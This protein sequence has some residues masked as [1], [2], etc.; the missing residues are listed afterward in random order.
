MLAGN[1]SHLGREDCKNLSV[2]LRHIQ[3]RTEICV[4]RPCSPP[5]KLWAVDGRETDSHSPVNEDIRLLPWKGNQLQ[6]TGLPD[7]AWGFIFNGVAGTYMPWAWP[8]LAA[9]LSLSSSLCPC[10]LLVTKVNRG[11]WLPGASLKVHKCPGCKNKVLPNGFRFLRACDFFLIYLFGVCLCRGAAGAVLLMLIPGV[12]VDHWLTSRI[13]TLRR[14]FRLKGMCNERKWMVMENEQCVRN[15]TT[16]F[17]LRGTLALPYRDFHPYHAKSMA[18]FKVV[19]IQLG[20]SIQNTNKLLSAW[21][22]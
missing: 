20:N 6:T 17:N 15:L 9:A 16:N 7:D 12:W 3:I 13:R 22:F 10:P 11:L 2:W 18:Q 21:T 19:N 14:L 4:A 5:R 8:C 1:P